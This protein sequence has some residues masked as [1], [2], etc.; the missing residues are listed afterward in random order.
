MLLL[1][2]Q[3]GEL[4]PGLFSDIDECPTN[5][6]RLLEEATHV[7]RGRFGTEER[8]SLP[9]SECTPDATDG[10]EAHSRSSG[11]HGSRISG[12]NLIR[13]ETENETYLSPS[14]LI[15]PA[16][17]FIALQHLHDLLS[18]ESSSRKE[19]VPIFGLQMLTDC[20][21]QAA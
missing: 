20:R 10:D 3:E 9:A 17:E 21:Y 12:Q 6:L 7:R 2:V 19:S 16:F 11:V 18:P 4:R 13:R 5:A 15:H 8:E 14:T 1:V